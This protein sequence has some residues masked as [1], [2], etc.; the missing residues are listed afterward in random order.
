MR[1]QL[2]ELDRLHLPSILRNATSRSRLGVAMGR[3][4]QRGC[5]SPSAYLSV[6]K[7]FFWFLCNYPKFGSP[8]WRS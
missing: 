2:S 3:L 5:E 1:L 7:G 6:F 4:E 8:Q